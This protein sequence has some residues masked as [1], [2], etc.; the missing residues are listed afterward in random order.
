MR[1]A[2]YLR[3]SLDRDGGGLAVSRQRQDCRRLAEKRGWTVV[4]EFVDNDVSASTGR[5]R[6]QYANLL[7]AIEADQV[8][9]VVVWAADRLHRRPVELEHF[10]DVADKHGTALATVSG[11]IDLAS[12]SGRLVA[13][14]LGAVA[15]GEM[16][17]KSSRQRRANLQRAETGSP[18]FTRRPFGYSTDGS[19]VV[20]AEAKVLRQVAAQLLA[21]ATLMELCSDLNRRGI[22][23]S[24]GNPWHVTSLRNL[25]L[26][27]RHAGLNS[28]RGEVLGQGS[29]PAILDESTHRAVVALLSN[30]ARRTASSTTSKY[31][32][33]G[34]A[35][36]GRCGE[37]MFASP[38][39]RKG[40]YWMVYKC[41]T[42][43]LARRL[44][45]VDEVVVGV[46]LGRLARPDAVD[47]LV[48]PQVDDADALRGEATAIR[49]H[50]DDTAGLFADGTITAV[51]LRKVTERLRERLA[52]VELKQAASRP[53]HVLADL[54]AA[55]DLAAMWAELPLGRQRAVVDLL[56]E[57]II[58]PAGKGV[59]F[60]ED[61][62]KVR[63][64]VA[65]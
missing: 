41:R 13:R 28:Y 35:R 61:Q 27:P 65:R 39:G 8:D 36:C 60:D 40:D 3:Q 49:T 26:N 18:R 38:M 52:A 50:L 25:L 48:N 15:R 37:A 34:L 29:W 17:T 54:V 43:H 21:G 1:A 44:D 24:L 30:P 56:L 16:E 45:L 63:W 5:Q 12:P 2:L 42:A 46:V 32:L 10:I 11:D 59:R 6:P 58:L 19:S 4:G 22:T 14:L 57:V 51:Q 62:V 7:A 31:L 53:G 33:S 55:P 9:A 47:L 20:E 64:K 23:T